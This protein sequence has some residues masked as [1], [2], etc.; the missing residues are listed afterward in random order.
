MLRGN[1]LFVDEEKQREEMRRSL[2]NSDVQRRN[3]AILFFQDHG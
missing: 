2:A 3:N 1:F